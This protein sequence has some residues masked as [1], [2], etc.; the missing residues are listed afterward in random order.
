[1]VAAAPCGARIS[2]A[3]SARL[4]AGRALQLPAELRAVLASPIAGVGRGVCARFQPPC[5]GALRGA[6]CVLHHARLVEA[7]Q[8]PLA[9]TE[10]AAPG[11]AG[12]RA[13]LHLGTRSSL[14]RCAGG[15]IRSL[16]SQVPPPAQRSARRSLGSPRA[17]A[18]PSRRGLTA[19]EPAL[20]SCG[21][22]GGKRVRALR[23]R[24]YEGAELA[25]IGALFRAVHAAGRGCW[26]KNTV[27]G[28]CA[29]AVSTRN[30]G[31]RT[32]RG[33]E[34]FPKPYFWPPQPSPVFANRRFCPQLIHLTFANRRFCP[35][36]AFV[37]WMAEPAG[38]MS[39]QLGVAPG[40]AA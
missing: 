20:A 29:F 7:Q 22:R 32:S 8:A 4:G 36:S 33:C 38:R 26:D 28:T 17:K 6:V 12:F 23:A 16:R 21:R 30:T 1:M 10:T 31:W 35:C 13:G 37:L 34:T 14:P 24:A 27:C 3:A 39:C 40:R 9:V 11:G 18:R 5:C 25:R 2:S 19:R 15:T